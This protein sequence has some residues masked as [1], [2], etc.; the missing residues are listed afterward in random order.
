MADSDKKANIIYPAYI[1]KNRTVARGRRIPL[2]FAV[3]DPKPNEVVDA[4]FSLKGFQAQPEAKPYC[5]ELDK[6]SV[7]WRIRYSNTNPSKNNLANKKQVLVACAK[8]I[9]EVR[10]KSGPSTSNQAEGAGGGGGGSG[11]QKKKK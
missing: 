4:L 10:A 6:E 1:N 9:N 11:K 5:R 7:P 3:A 2:Q 8:R